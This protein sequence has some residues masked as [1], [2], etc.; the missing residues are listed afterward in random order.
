MKFSKIRG[1]SGDEVFGVELKVP[2]KKVKQIE[3]E[4]LCSSGN[5]YSKRRCIMNYLFEIVFVF[6][7]EQDAKDFSITATINGLIHNDQ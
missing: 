5:L 6:E 3:E 4:F 2:L 1:F 7:R